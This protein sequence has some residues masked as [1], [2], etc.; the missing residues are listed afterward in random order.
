MN[1]IISSLNK[2]IHKIWD[3]N[4]RILWDRSEDNPQPIANDQFNTNLPTYPDSQ[5]PRQNMACFRMGNGDRSV[6]GLI[7][8]LNESK[9]QPMRKKIKIKSFAVN[10]AEG[11]GTV[12]VQY[13][14]LHEG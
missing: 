7:F 9:D 10:V 12:A 2:H 3:P 14:S 8:H 13:D 6:N 5:F 4:T 11:A 1:D